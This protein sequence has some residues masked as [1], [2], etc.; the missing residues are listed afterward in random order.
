MCVHDAVVWLWN[1]P[2]ES[3][4]FILAD[5]RFDVW[6]VNDRASRY[7]SHTSLTS[8]ERVLILNDEFGI[9]YGLGFPIFINS[10]YWWTF[11]QDKN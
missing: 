5:S 1:F 7:S 6:I 4:A 2:D 10:S 8:N 3:L 11:N 9:P